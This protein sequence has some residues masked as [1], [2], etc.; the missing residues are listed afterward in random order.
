VY[1]SKE[2]GPAN[3]RS[4][5]NTTANMMAIK[6]DVNESPKTK[7]N[8]TEIIPT[9]KNKRNSNKYTSGGMIKLYRALTLFSKLEV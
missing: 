3:E 5:N 7:Y 8:I 6:M 9:K 4:G 1:N 2:L